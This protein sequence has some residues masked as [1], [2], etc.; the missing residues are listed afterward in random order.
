MGGGGTCGGNKAESAGMACG[1]AQAVEMRHHSRRL[2]GELRGHVY[3]SRSTLNTA[4]APPVTPPHMARCM[5]DRRTARLPCCR[6]LW[7]PRRFGSTSSTILASRARSTR[8]GACR[9]S[10]SRTFSFERTRASA[11][12]PNPPSE[13]RTLPKKRSRTRKVGLTPKI[14]QRV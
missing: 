1:W 2:R 9:A 7:L 10:S 3:R 8:G 5:S 12:I 13:I 4:A 14:G 11:C 6:S